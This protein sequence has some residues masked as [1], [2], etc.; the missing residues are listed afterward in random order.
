MGD[1]TFRVVTRGAD[2]AIRHRDY[3]SRETML[4]VHSQVGIDDC[5][6]DLSLRGLP[7]C[8]G[9]IGPI[10]ESKTIVRYE[11]P[12]V[13]ET[14]TKEWTTSPPAPKTRRRRRATATE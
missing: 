10:P 14:L 12:E 13:F 6:T 11:S 9:L 7:V 2:G 1:P 4:K 8:R 5:S 3:P